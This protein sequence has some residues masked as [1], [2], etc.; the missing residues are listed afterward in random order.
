[1]TLSN[2]L[3]SYFIIVSTIIGLGIFVLPYTFWQSGYYF[4]LWLIFWF[5]TFLILHLIFGEIL[6][7]TKE[8]HNLPGL[9]GVYLHPFMKHIVWFFDYFGMLG[10]FLIYFIALVKFW[11]LIFP[12]SPLIIKILFAL[13]NLYFIFKDIRIFAK[14]ETILTLGILFVFFFVTLMI[15]PNF[16]FNNIEL[17]L[18]N[19]FQPFLPYGTILFALAGTSALP[20]V[21][22]LIGQ[23]RK[24][25]LKINFYAL[26]TVIVLYLIY[27]LIVVGFLGGEVSEESLVGLAPYFPKLFL[28]LA[29]LF[30]TLNITF[31]DMAFYLKRGL[32]YDYKVRPRIA[33]FIIFISILPLIFLEP[34]SLIKLIGL[35]SEIFLGFN[36]LILCLVYLK[37]KK[38][39]YFSLPNFF[40][41]ILA[42]IFISGIIYGILPN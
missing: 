2:E 30:V 6:F 9:A 1:M 27:A 34:L 26:L 12:V 41:I 32:I 36:L 5:L 18:K 22:D 14:M 17:A 42:L 38:K 19:N 25:Y 24:S 16:N 37:L 23:N 28:I 39:E 7:Q 8:K 40:I 10:V 31:A 21:F 3:K 29:V 35:V 20:I 4:F 15:L 11:T 33:N 13:F